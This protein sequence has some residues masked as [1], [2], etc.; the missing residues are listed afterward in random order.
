LKSSHSGKRSKEQMQGLLD[1][2]DTLEPAV[3]NN[4][5]DFTYLNLSLLLQA[6]ERCESPIEQLMA[7]SMSPLIQRHLVAGLRSLWVE[8][9]IPL[10]T[11]EGNYRADFL[12]TAIIS[13]VRVRTIVECDGHEFHERTKEQATRDK[14]RDR[15]LQKAGYSVLRFSGSEIWANSFACAEQVMEFLK[16]KAERREE[17]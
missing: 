12:I 9:Q 2:L 1:R 6:M 11:P 16:S 4:L 14:R 7:Y 10:A 8:Q 3:A 13:G 5:R 17:D 15:A